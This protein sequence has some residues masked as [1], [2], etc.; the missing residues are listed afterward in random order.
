MTDTL[1]TKAAKVLSQTRSLDEA[2]SPY[3]ISWVLEVFCM[4]DSACLHL[5][6]YGV[7]PEPL[8]GG[9]LR[10][11]DCNLRNFGITSGFTR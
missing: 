9:V 2:P 6:V 10:R 7:P 11:L 8:S 1:P 4:G 5:A 3:G